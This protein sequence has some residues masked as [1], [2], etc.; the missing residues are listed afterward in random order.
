M[1]APILF[2][3]FNRPDT[4]RLVFE[5]IRRAKPNRLYVAA[6]GAR[7]DRPGEAEKV[8]EV[9]QIVGAVDWPCEVKNLYRDTNKGCKQAVSEAI[10]WFFENEDMGI[11]LEDDCLP[12]PTFFKFCE[13]LLE[14]YRHDDRIMAI[15]GTNL[16]NTDQME[17]SYYFSGIPHIWGWASWSRVWQEYDV[18]MRDIEQVCSSIAAKSHF[19]KH[20]W[21]YWKRFFREVQCGLVN[22]WDVQF[23]YLAI[24]SG[25]LS[26]FPKRNLISNI[27]FGADATHTTGESLLANR[28][29]YPIEADLNHPVVFQTNQ[30]AM[31][32]REVVESWGMPRYLRVA[33]TLTSWRGIKII[34]AKILNS[35]A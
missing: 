1:Q 28:A 24:K 31:R 13:T 20:I 12:D 2:L 18:E 29:V 26:I 15:C 35:I 19:S 6:D 11:I 21:Q 4:T 14:R 34:A 33:K 25:R 9:K 7:G 10:S 32:E 8:E 17:D 27:G 3:V 30:V 16:A 5:A 23:S 22:T